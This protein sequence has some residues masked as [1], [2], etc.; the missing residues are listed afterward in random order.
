MFDLKDWAAR[1][2]DLMNR[3]VELVGVAPAPEVDL[4][5]PEVRAV[6]AE[7]VRMALEFVDAIDDYGAANAVYA[8]FQATLGTALAIRYPEEVIANDVTVRLAQ[9]ANQ[10]P[11]TV[12]LLW[13]SDEEREAKARD[14][15][16]AQVEEAAE[17]GLALLEE[18]A[19]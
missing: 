2:L 15:V 12:A 18:P 10:D 7:G 6:R 4:E 14:Y 11:F 1:A 5:A 19:E 3:T 13:G 17:V 9:L 16:T 8:G